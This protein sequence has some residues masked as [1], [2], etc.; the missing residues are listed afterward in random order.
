MPS[1]KMMNLLFFLL[2]VFQV[3]SGFSLLE[4]VKGLCDV[5]GA[6]RPNSWADPCEWTTPCEGARGVP[7]SGTTC[8]GEGHL[9]EL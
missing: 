2:F 7:L 1:F 6:N 9:I 8:D 3:S 4:E 5:F